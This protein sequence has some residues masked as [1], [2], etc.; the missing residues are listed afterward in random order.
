AKKFMKDQEDN[1]SEQLREI[2]ISKEM[3]LDKLSGLKTDKSPGPD[4]LHPRVLKEVATEIV[5]GMSIIFQTSVDTGKVPNDWKIANVTPL[6]KKGGRENRENYR[7]VSLMSVV[8]KILECS[9]L[10]HF[11]G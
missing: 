3:V 8:G 6:F 11:Q 4:G 5:D 1:G 9:V 2:N 10:E 7:P